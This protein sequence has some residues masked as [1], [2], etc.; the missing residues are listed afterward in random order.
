VR[1]RAAVLPVLVAAALAEPGAAGAPRRA[2]PVGPP[3]LAF[4]STTL[5]PD[6]HRID[7]RIQAMT[8][9]RVRLLLSRRGAPLGRLDGMVH[10]GQTVLG[11]AVPQRVL[12][13]LHPGHHVDVTIYFGAPEPVRIHGAVLLRGDPELSL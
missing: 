7:V 8:D 5:H 11:V 6:V 4:R 10:S 2:G 12:R 3:P 1:C 13:R 9:V